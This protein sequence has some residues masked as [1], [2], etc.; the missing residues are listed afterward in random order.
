MVN[1]DTTVVAE[2]KYMSHSKK[3]FEKAE[4]EASVAE[5]QGVRGYH[6]QENILLKAG[7]MSK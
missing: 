1:R 5:Q 3:L 2:S 6:K 4:K 7:V